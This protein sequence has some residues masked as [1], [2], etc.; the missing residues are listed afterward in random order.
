ME[1]ILKNNKNG[2]NITVRMVQKKIYEMMKDIDKLCEKNNID[3]FLTDGT[4]LGAVRHKGFIPWDDDLDIGMSRSDYIKFIKA[5]EKDLPDKYVYHC[6]EKI[7]K[8]IVTWPAMK[9]RLKN[10]Y[11]KERNVL[12]KNKCKDCDGIFID[13][14][15][16]DSVSNYKIFDIPFRLVNTLLMPII[17]F[18]E[19]IY[20]NPIP[21]KSF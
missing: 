9:I 2:K 20:I 17:V 15:I 6:Y 16:Y 1:Y 4:C 3:Y 5:L 10:T 8:Y 11:I 21:L 18:F 14:F 7:K 12:L 13:V 19:N